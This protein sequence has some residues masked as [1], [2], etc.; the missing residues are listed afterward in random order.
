MTRLVGVEEEMFLVDPVS[1]R[2]LARSHRVREVDDRRPDAAPEDVVQELFLEQVETTTEPAAD[3]DGLRAHVLA[4][5]RR[6]SADADAVG[7]AILPSP[8]AVV[9]RARDVTPS[10]RYRRM[11]SRHRDL[12]PDVAVCAM[13]VHV[14]VEDDEEAVRVVDRLAP[15]LPV[16]AALAA[17]SPFVHG[18]DTGYAS[19]RGRQWDRW[20]TAGPTTP[21]GDA[22]TYRQ[23]VQAMIDSGAALD[24]GMVYLD[25]RPGRSTPTVEV[26]VSDVLADVDDA[27]VV[28]GLV[29]ALVTRVAEPSGAA[30]GEEPE[31]PRPEVLRAARWLAQHDGLGERLLDPWSGR[32][33][34]AAVAVGSLVQHVEGGFG[35]DDE[36]AL[37]VD[38]VRR[39]LS[40]GGP[41][42]RARTVA[43][44]D[45]S[46]WVRHLLLETQRSVGP[47]RV[48][49]PAA[50]TST[51]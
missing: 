22:A 17:G 45:A 37:V 27:V 15:W 9:G 20:P 42:G 31:P 29:R 26:R 6:A 46:R 13:H 18:V 48:D 16:V 21:F 51:A 12:F 7:A 11:A 25:A 50:G 10:P 49:D 36:R 44:G 43:D 39:L 23:A 4:A 32:P 33:V 5:R 34:P 47:R 19:W 41:A 28:A 3:L 38:G 1:G 40:E 2:P 30:S 8:T 14:D 35:S 24:E